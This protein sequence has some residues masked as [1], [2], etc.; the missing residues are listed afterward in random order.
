M[1]DDEHF[2]M[3]SGKKLDDF[4]AATQ[5]PHQSLENK[6]VP[7][8]INASEQHIRDKPSKK[9]ILK[10]IPKASWLAKRKTIPDVM[11]P[12]RQEVLPHSNTHSTSDSV[13]HRTQEKMAACVKNMALLE[14]CRNML[15]MKE[16]LGYLWLYARWRYIIMTTANS[17]TTN[18]SRHILHWDNL[19]DTRALMPGPFC[20]MLWKH[21]PRHKD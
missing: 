17:C 16:K 21:K 10:L 2:F 7:N 9:I 18:C 13:C 19:A 11:Q 15:A 20:F 14:Q 1:P 3:I 6:S 12:K 8:A 4:H 5:T